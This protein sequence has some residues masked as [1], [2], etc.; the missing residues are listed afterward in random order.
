MKSIATPSI[1]LKLALT[2]LCGLLSSCAL[3]ARDYEVL[4]SY[5]HY[6]QGF[7]QGLELY[8]GRLYESSGQYGHSFLLHGNLTST[9]LKTDLAADF[10]AEGLT[11]YQDQLYLLSWRKGEALVFNPDTL[12]E[13][14]K[15]SYTGEGW[16]LTHSDHEL[17]MSDGSDE[18]RV[19]D[20]ETFKEKRRIAVHLRGK[21]L[22]HLN[23]LEWHRGLI[24]AN[25]WQSDWIVA[26][27]A[28]SGEVLKTFDLSGLFPRAMRGAGSD[29]L[30][31]IA[32][33]T[34]T[35]SWLLT[36][37]YWPRIYR[38]RLQLPLSTSADES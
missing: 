11:V 4:A 25:V 32:Y 36:G 26:I 18:L 17:Y 24:L 16:G 7:T 28:N 8:K 3:Q 19:M 23:E 21:P 12:E 2:I 35:D 13:T 6:S 31:G 27:D 33:D 5:P 29:V 20:P 38:I 14:A 30:N 22:K 15:F 34:S 9:S 10:F 37:K 1:Q